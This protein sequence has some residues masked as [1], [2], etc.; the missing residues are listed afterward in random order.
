MAGL[1]GGGQ[2]APAYTPAPPEL[3]KLEEPKVMPIADPEAQKNEELRKMA[4]AQKGRT[5]RRNTI[6]GGDEDTL[7]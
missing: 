5:S 7:G 3:P 1:F 4:Q 6:I 2:S